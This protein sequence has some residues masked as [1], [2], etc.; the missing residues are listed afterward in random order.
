M[1]IRR[2]LIVDSLAAS[3]GG[4]LGV[5]FRPP[6]ISN[7]PRG[8][9]EGGADWI[10]LGLRRTVFFLLAILLAPIAGNRFQLPRRRRR[11]F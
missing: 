9:A 4:M 5:S 10:A 3:I 11:S 8:V 6:P 2:I 1:G 7:L